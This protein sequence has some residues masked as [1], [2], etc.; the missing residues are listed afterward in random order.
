MEMSVLDIVLILYM[1][2]VYW[3]DIY[4]VKMVSG[5]VVLNVD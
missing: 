1:G 2:I 3:L 5:L 4:I